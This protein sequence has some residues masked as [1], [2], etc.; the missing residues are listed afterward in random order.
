MGWRSP[1]CLGCST[2]VTLLT[3]FKI[4]QAPQASVDTSIRGV[5]SSSVTLSCLHLEHVLDL[6]SGS[7]L[8]SVPDSTNSPWFNAPLLLFPAPVSFPHHTQCP[9]FFSLLN[10]IPQ[11]LYTSSDPAALPS[12][13]SC[14]RNAGSRPQN[15]SVAVVGKDFSLIKRIAGGGLS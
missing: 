13:G 1:S 5:C 12:L 2:A 15:P 9:I 10:S 14:S 7:W 6:L 3:V 4:C 8:I 11:L